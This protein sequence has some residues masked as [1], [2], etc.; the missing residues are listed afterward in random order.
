MIKIKKSLTTMIEGR[1]ERE[2]TLRELLP[3]LDEA[4]NSWDPE[5]ESSGSDVRLRVVK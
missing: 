1:S 2:A 3:E 4:D 5:S